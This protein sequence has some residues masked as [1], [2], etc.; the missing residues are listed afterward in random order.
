MVFMAQYVFSGSCTI[1]DNGEDA[2]I[3]GP[4]VMSNKPVTV[5]VKSKDLAR[6]NAGGYV[7]DCFPYLSASDREFLLSGIS[8]EAWDEMFPEEDSDE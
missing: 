3:S 1:N 7:Q 2:V 8:G 4:C 5:T 6:Y